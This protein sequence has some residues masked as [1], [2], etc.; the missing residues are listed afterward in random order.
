MNYG[1]F[2]KHLLERFNWV[3]S[4]TNNRDLFCEGQLHLIIP[5]DDE[6]DSGV[7]VC[8]SYPNDQ[9]AKQIQYKIW[10]NEDLQKVLK[11]VVNNIVRKITKDSHNTI[12]VK[13]RVATSMLNCLLLTKQLAIEEN[14]RIHDN[15]V[16]NLLDLKRDS[17]E[18]NLPFQ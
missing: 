3:K 4:P 11:W 7:F 2:S 9:I 15:M 8:S 14:I 1:V 5:Y 18:E 17:M 13:I 10:Y 6:I 16:Q 12:C